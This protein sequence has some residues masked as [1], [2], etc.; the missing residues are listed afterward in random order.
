[1]KVRALARRI[2]DQDRIRE[3]AQRDEFVAAGFASGAFIGFV[4]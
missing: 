3:L 1:M 2:Y 4:I